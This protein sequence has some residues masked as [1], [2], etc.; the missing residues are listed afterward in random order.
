MKEK[1]I[2][3]FGLLSI[4][5]IGLPS[6]A[7][8]RGGSG[9]LIS[10]LLIALLVIF[11]IFLILREAV[12]WYWKINE[13]ISLL[14]EIRDLLKNRDIDNSIGNVSSET[15]Y[16]SDDSQ[17]EEVISEE[18]ILEELANGDGMSELPP[19]D[20]EIVDVDNI[21]QQS[22]TDRFADEYEKTREVIV[23]EVSKNLT[24]KEELSTLKSLSA[25]SYYDLLDMGSKL[26]DLSDTGQKVYQALMEKIAATFVE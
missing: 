16:E 9:D 6:Y 4:L 24:S 2:S 21:E 11:V 20:S 12:C 10:S 13:R 3:T 17:Y 14:K 1:W 15:S 22:N 7:H 8:A 19:T 23:S 5:T 26:E 18:E 25:R